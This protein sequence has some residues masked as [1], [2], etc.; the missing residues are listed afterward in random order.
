[1]HSP[2]YILYVEDLSASTKLYEK[3]L[4]TT[5]LQASETFVMFQEKSGVRVGIK[6]AERSNSGCNE[7]A[8]TVEDRQTVS[9]LHEE[10][11]QQGLAIL[12]EPTDVGYGFT[13]LAKDA[14]GHRLRVVAVHSHE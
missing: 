9:R 2:A 11:I 7:L 10:W 5:P 8:F 14:D 1:M 4:A 12:Q 3:L 6:K 13:F